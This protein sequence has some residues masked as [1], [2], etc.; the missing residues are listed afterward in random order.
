MQKHWIDSSAFYFE[1]LYNPKQLLILDLNLKKSS[2]TPISK[3][4]NRR[5]PIPSILF[6]GNSLRIDVSYLVDRKGL[7]PLAR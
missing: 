5:K 6:F 7:E 2:L 3:N 1:Y 4:K